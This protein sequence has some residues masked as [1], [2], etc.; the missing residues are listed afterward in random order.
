MMN[1][2]ESILNKNQNKISYSSV[3]YSNTTASEIKKN[4]LKCWYTNAT[5]LNNKWDQFKSEIILDSYPDLIFVT[6]TW[7]N[8]YSLRNID[9]YKLFSKDR[10]YS[11]INSPPND[12]F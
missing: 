9:Q 5:S 3:C 1:S 11:D 12:D 6:E 8:D 10:K 2:I 7:F 4:S